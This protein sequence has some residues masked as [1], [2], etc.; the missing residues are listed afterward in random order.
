MAIPISVFLVTLQTVPVDSRFRKSVISAT[1]NLVS[2]VQLGL[3]QRLF[4]FTFV[5]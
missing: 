1:V 3:T 5:F 2:R 4:E